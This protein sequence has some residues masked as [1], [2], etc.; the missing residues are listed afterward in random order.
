MMPN[1]VA[2]NNG[3]GKSSNKDSMMAGNTGG[4]DIRAGIIRRSYC[5]ERPMLY[6]F[7]NRERSFL[8]NENQTFSDAL[9]WVLLMAAHVAN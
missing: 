5:H 8:L 2:I 1:N 4:C 7:T 6:L 9:I 3:T